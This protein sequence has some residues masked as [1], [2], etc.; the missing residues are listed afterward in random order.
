MSYI[1]CYKHELVGQFG[2]LPVYRPLEEIAGSLDP[3][4]DEFRCLPNQLVLG[5]GGGEHPGM[6]LLHPERAVAE[7][8][9]YHPDIELPE[10]LENNIWEQYISSNTAFLYSGWSTKDHYDFYDLCTGP[11]LPNRF[12]PARGIS[13]ES[14]LLSG[15]GEFIYYAMP[16]LVTASL[17]EKINSLA[18]P[19][20]IHFNN[21]LIVPPRMPVYA[22]GGNSFFK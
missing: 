16:E 10:E 6:V 3:N 12:N 7:F 22:N 9:I 2:H 4:D 14:W 18:Q 8:A 11:G 19:R 17:V 21:I 13:F 5:G 20:H 1:D 15:F